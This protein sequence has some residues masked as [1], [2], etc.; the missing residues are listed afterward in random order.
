MGTKSP[1]PGCPPVLTVSCSGGLLSDGPRPSQKEIVSLRAFMLLFLK[2]LI[3]KVRPRVLVCGVVSVGEPNHTQTSITSEPV[4][5]GARGSV[6]SD[7]PQRL[8]HTTA[9][10]RPHLGVP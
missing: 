6:C 4:P 7:Q 5:L 3:L 10:R 2:Q 1:S 9:C 8:S